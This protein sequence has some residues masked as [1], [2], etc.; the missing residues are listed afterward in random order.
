MIKKRD[1]RLNRVNAGDL[2]QY[3]PLDQTHLYA[4]FARRSQFGIGSIAAA[5]LGDD[6]IN[7]MGAQQRHLV[8]KRKRAA[9]EHITDARHVKARLY[10]LNAAD[11]IIVLRRGY[12]RLQFLP[13]KGG[14]D[15]PGPTANR[16]MIKCRRQII[17]LKTQIT[18]LCTPR[19]A[20]NGEMG[21]ARLPYRRC[22]IG[23][24]GRR[25]RVSC[26]NQH[27]DPVLPQ[28]SRQTSHAAKSA[29][30][31][32]YRLRDRRA[33]TPGQRHHAI[34]LRPPCNRL[35]KL[36]RLRRAAQDENVVTHAIY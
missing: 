36:A 32:R 16:T 19:R 6:K 20:A 35:G 1:C 29:N 4:Q 24:Y 22:R 8:V 33:R 12:K 13:A 23:G 11:Q 17:D 30:A 3:R 25:E 21:R 7:V 2:R 31:H 15:A 26:I 27:I 10:R 5:I 28:I 9:I 34:K 14:K 18:G